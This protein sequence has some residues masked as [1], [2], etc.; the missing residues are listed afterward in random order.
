MA[1]S[2]PVFI[3]LFMPVFFLLYLIISKSYLNVLILIASLIFY[4]V[5]EP[6]YLWVLA[7][8]IVVNYAFGVLIDELIGP[9]NVKSMTPRR[10]PV[11]ALGLGIILDLGIL[12]Y[13]KYA[14]FLTSNLAAAASS[15]GMGG[16]IS[17]IE[18]VLPLGVSF[19]TFQG[20]SY[21]IDV[22]RGDVRPTRSLLK[23]AT[24]KALFP[25][26]IAGP[27]VRYAEV[28]G[29]MDKRAVGVSQAFE[30][31]RRFTV[32]FIKKVMIADTCAVCADAI[33][34]A[35]P[36]TLSTAAAWLGAIS[37]AIQIYFDFSAYSD[38]AIGLG[39]MMGFHYPENFKHPYVSGSVREFWRRWHMTLSAWFRDYVYRPLGGNRSGATRTYLNLI[40]VFAL[41]GLWHGASWTFVA[42][43]LWHGVFML[44]ERRFDPEAW[45]VP[46]FV[47]HIYLLLV[48]LFGWVLF[49]ADSFEG[50]FGMMKRM[51]SMGAG[52]VTRGAAEFLN[53]LLVLTLVAG[54]VLCAPVHNWIRSRLSDM[55]AWPL[56]V[57][58]LGGAFL[59][60]CMKV[61]SG[62]YSPF[63]YFRF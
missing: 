47:R 43:G 10:L 45:P 38:M 11:L 54:V 55:W 40:S 30:G 52:D 57:V 4:Y 62:A 23:F 42:W 60:A 16:H 7:F 28:A 17:I 1:F 51:L 3:F 6:R 53:P 13:F 19:F 46:A 21:L 58:T 50:A 22:Y 18:Q 29:E 35:D 56:G 61:L 27:I 36:T 63:L 26:L 9:R 48:V 49:R 5:G 14:G 39:L 37:Y 2:D 44:V 24:Y 33:F 32:G 34:S 8:A 25:Q 20:V 59:V 15:I 41:T 31:V 12:A